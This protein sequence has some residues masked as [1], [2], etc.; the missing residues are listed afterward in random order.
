[1]EFRDVISRDHKLT[2]V[3]ESDDMKEL[4][5]Y[6][7]QSVRV[8]PGFPGPVKVNDNPVPAVGQGVVEIEVRVF[9]R[10]VNQRPREQVP[11]SQ[12]YVTAPLDVVYGNVEILD[13]VSVDVEVPRIGFQTNCAT[14]SI[15][16]KVNRVRFIRYSHL[17]NMTAF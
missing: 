7:V 4:P 3:I 8:P 14:C 10:R 13:P 9:Q 16:I 12:G 5:Q 1:M 15:K 11:R 2:P 6:D 17:V